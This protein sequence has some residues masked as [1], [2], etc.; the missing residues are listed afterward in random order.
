MP[1]SCLEAASRTSPGQAHGHTP[2]GLLSRVSQ[3]WHVGRP[4]QLEFVGQGSEQEGLH[5]RSSGGGGGLQSPLQSTDL[6]G[7]A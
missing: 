7:V 4:R 2:A 3:D 5:L 6:A 1:A